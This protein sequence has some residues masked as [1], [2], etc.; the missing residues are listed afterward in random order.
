MKKYRIFATIVGILAV[1]ATALVG[2]TKKE[3]ISDNNT[4]SI[5]IGQSHNDGLDYIC[6]SLNLIN[7]RYEKTSN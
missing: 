3:M 1:I 7:T 5:N 4:Q 6:K 2:C